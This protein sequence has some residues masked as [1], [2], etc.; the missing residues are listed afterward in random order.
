MNWDSVY[1]GCG[2]DV[3]PHRHSL[4]LHLISRSPPSH[5]CQSSCCPV[6]LASF[7]S[8]VVLTMLVSRLLTLT[9]LL[10]LSTSTLLINYSVPS[11]FST[12]G[13]CQLEGS[14][15]SDHI[16]CPGNSSIYIK[17]DTNP[18]GK[19]ALHYHRDPTFRRAEVKGVGRTRK[20][21]IT[22]WDTSSGSGI[23]MGGWRSFS[24]GM[25][26]CSGEGLLAL[27]SA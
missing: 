27:S 23:C 18:D 3:L 13:Q 9:V 7:L 1:L 21:S 19:T 11:P 10:S 22:T 6:P 15:H 4:S 17:T 12:L 5:K 25:L 16:A 20:I 24:G 26:R 2:E 14:F 8:P